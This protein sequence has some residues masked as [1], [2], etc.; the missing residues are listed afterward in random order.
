MQT[1]SP[2][3]K[4][5]EMQIGQQRYA[6]YVQRGEILPP[7]SPLYATLT[8]IANAIAAVANRE[9]F[10]PFHFFLLNE[11]VPNAMAMPGGNVYVTTAMMSFLKNRDQLAGVLCHEVNHDIH[12]DMYNVYRAAQMGQG[13]AGVAPI[14]F[15]RAA[16][17]NAD[18][19]GAYLCAKAGFNPWGMAWNL[20][21]HRQAMGPSRQTAASDHPS[22]DQRLADITALFASDPGTFGRFK[23]NV[24]ASIPLA[25]GYAQGPAQSAYAPPNRPPYPPQQYPQQYPAQQYPGPYPPPPLPACYPGC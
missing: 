6:Q 16:E 14:G 19:A 7:Q 20:M 24:A 22:D 15:E 18:R 11:A 23:N 1:V 13:Q 17:S 12:H 3:E 21:E 5:W 4:N 9:Y 10:T 2:Q 25:S 8:P